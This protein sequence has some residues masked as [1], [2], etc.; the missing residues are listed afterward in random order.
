[1]AAPLIQLLNK[2]A[3][4]TWNEEKEHAFKELKNA[5]VKAGSLYLPTPKGKFKIY[6]DFS[7]EAVAAIL[8]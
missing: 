4:W 6:T 2:E 7:S 5:L 1:M 8:H 3:K